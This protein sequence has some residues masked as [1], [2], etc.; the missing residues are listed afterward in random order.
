MRIYLLLIFTAI[1]LSFSTAYFAINLQNNTSAT[2]KDMAVI[3]FLKDE[4]VKEAQPL[5]EI[6]L[7]SLYPTREF[8]QL[9]RPVLLPG[10]T[11]NYSRPCDQL[12]NKTKQYYDKSDL[13]EDFRC[14][15]TDR[16][17]EKFFESAPLLH[18]S[19]QSY[20]WLA[21]VSG[22]E[23]YSG[24]DWARVHLNYFHINELK[25]IPP[26][27]LDGNFII[28]S[29]LAKDDLQ[30]LGS[31]KDQFLTRLYFLNRDK[32]SLD[33]N[34]KFYSREHFENFFKAKNYFLRQKNNDEKCFYEE[35][36]ICFEKDSAQYLELFKKSSLLI[37]FFSMMVLFLV[38][39]IL[40][41]KIKQQ[42]FEE[43]R[44]KHALRVLTHELRTPIANLLLQ[45]E[46][47]NRESSTLNPQ[48]QDEFLKMEEEVYRLKRLAEKSRGYLE[49]QSGNNLIN[50]ENRL[51]P[52][53]NELLA[54]LLAPYTEKGVQFL[55]ASSDSEFSVD[56][57]WLNVCLKNLVENAIVH[58]KAPVVVSLTNTPDSLQISVSDQGQ[59][60]YN[61]LN[62]IM[63]DNRPR[64]PK[65]GMGLGLILVA[66]IVSELNGK[67]LMKKNPTTFTLIFKK[68]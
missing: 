9:I 57:Y 28:L 41:R 55:P 8:F 18:E 32:T 52:S 25:D 64:D 19:G 31:G 7:S 56:L 67:L 4:F 23:N 43:E 47:I 26:A 17:P 63:D 24:S 53:H 58:G 48:L 16:L 21:L 20:A 61:S 33:L 42:K 40:F 54:E 46:N 62:E 49:M 50:A 38:A 27:A 14:H 11:N 30:A 10:R 36:G 39:V 22:N 59:C 1:T 68:S 6:N 29:R 34:Y 60:S 51:F 66:S 35:S 13:W 2:D 3:T 65:A 45:V 37:F 44:K 12:Q 5:A 15:H